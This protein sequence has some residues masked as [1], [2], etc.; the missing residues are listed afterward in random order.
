MTSTA[1]YYQLGGA[2]YDDG[3]MFDADEHHFNLQSPVQSHGLIYG[4]NYTTQGH[5]NELLAAALTTDGH[6]PAPMEHVDDPSRGPSST[7]IS[8][9]LPQVETQTIRKRKRTS[10]PDTPIPSQVE[11]SA[12][13]HPLPKRSKTTTNT[14]KRNAEVDRPALGVSSR[15][16]A[17]ARTTG[18]HSAAALFRRQS[19]SKAKKYTRP[20]MSKLY[21]SLNLSPENFLHLQSAAKAYMLNPDH[22]ERRDC[23][24]NRGKGD[25]DMVKLRL[26]NC[27]RDFLTDG[28]G[29]RFFSQASAAYQDGGADFGDEGEMP[30]EKYVWPRD[31]T[32]IVTL[33]VPLMRR[34]VTNERQRQYAVETR[35]GGAAKK[36]KSEDRESGVEYADHALDPTLPVQYERNL[37]I[38]IYVTSDNKMLLEPIDVPDNISLEQVQQRLQDSLSSKEESQK[39]NG[40]AQTNDTEKVEQPNAAASAFTCSAS[41]SVDPEVAATA[42]AALNAVNQRNGHLPQAMSQTVFIIKAHSVN[43]LLVVEDEAHWQGLKKEAANTVWMDYRLKIVAEPR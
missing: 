20:P 13:I 5:I 39:P 11:R 43:G 22:P 42:A 36:G 15:L 8:Q 32:K 19:E 7:I 33:V 12:S 28:V 2:T 29:E 41:A 6:Q 3:S 27:V 30:K 34:M 35:K 16:L 9:S 31:A 4:D 14:S 24:G 26:F 23:V 18:I 17:D 25:T 21:A 38:S 37:A 40:F 10:D 1:P